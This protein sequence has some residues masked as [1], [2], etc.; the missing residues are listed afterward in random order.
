MNRIRFAKRPSVFLLAAAAV[1]AAFTVWAAVPA[2]AS[3]ETAVSSMTA[4]KVTIP[5][6]SSY[7]TDSY[8]GVVNLTV[9]NNSVAYASLDSQNHV[10]ITAVGQGST[11]VSFLYRQSAGDSW[12]GMTIPI[13]VSGSAS[14]AAS[15][16]RG[17]QGIEFPQASV[18]V[19][20]GNS[21]TV[22]G[23]KINGF[24]VSSNELL[25]VSSDELV[26]DVGNK[27]GEIRGVSGGTATV[28]AIDPTT[29]ICNS[30]T[31]TVY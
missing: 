13:T 15:L 10:V 12:Y 22:T 25:W 17:T 30:V 7:V 5:A 23:M 18:A 11:S 19:A 21:T 27:T 4:S 16:S 31:V 1:A 6:N 29:K 8:F 9:G 14:S 20:K 3:T 24:A 2:S 28:Y 26:A